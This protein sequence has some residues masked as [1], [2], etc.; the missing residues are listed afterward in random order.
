MRDMSIASFGSGVRDA[1]HRLA[2]GCAGNG[3]ERA[4][5]NFHYCIENAASGQAPAVMPCR[6]TLCRAGPLAADIAIRARNDSV[7]LVADGHFG[8][9]SAWGGGSERDRR[10]EVR[11]TAGL[12]A[13]RSLLSY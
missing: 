6:R 2:T 7:R 13:A 4:G 12:L 5:Y 11:C 1:V 9:I 10:G 3:V 8:L